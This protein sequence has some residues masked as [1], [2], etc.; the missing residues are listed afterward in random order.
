MKPTYKATRRPSEFYVKRLRVNIAAHKTS[1][2]ERLRKQRDDERFLCTVRL[3]DY[4]LEKEKE[5][6][7]SLFYLN[8]A[9]EKAIKAHHLSELYSWSSRW[10]YAS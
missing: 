2:V 5:D 9:K 1:L 10:L 4:V 3:M 7:D 6:N 8:W